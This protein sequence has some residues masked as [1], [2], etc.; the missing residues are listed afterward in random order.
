MTE[1]EELKK[2]FFLNLYLLKYRQH[3]VL[4]FFRNNHPFSKKSGILSM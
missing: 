4:N 3:F 2:Y 1:K